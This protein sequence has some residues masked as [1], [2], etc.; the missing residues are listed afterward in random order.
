M[1][2]F[3]LVATAVAALLAGCG[4]GQ[5]PSIGGDAAA[6]PPKTDLSVTAKNTAFTPTELTA[7][8]GKA[9]TITFTNDDSIAH[10][11]HL[12]GGTA[13]EIKTDIKQGPSVETLQVTLNVPATYA[14]QCDVHPAKMKGT[15]VVVKATT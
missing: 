5:N 3:V 2:R 7:P 9:L 4:R 15:I 10:S 12:S 13:G 6:G 8:A 14:F 1:R 11:F